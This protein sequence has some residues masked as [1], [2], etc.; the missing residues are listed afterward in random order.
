MGTTPRFARP[1]ANVEG[2]EIDMSG[3]IGFH[4]SEATRELMEHHPKAFYLLAL[5]AQRARWKAPIVPDGLDKGQALIGVGDFLKIGWTE[6]AYRTAKEV[7]RR[8]RICDF[9]PARGTARPG[10][11]AT[12]L[13]ARVFS[14]TEQ[15][16]GEASDWKSTNV[17]RDGGE[18]TAKARRE[19]K[20]GKKEE[21]GLNKGKT[22]M[23]AEKVEEV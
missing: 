12:L 19:T 18:V 23:L 4:R 8:A 17:R 14:L 5:V 22:T 6:R 16:R 15:D 20:K 21:D 2:T 1:G 7:L 3:W 13:D 9:N 11:V 10:T